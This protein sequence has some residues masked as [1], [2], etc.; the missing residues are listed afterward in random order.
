MHFRRPLARELNGLAR[1]ATCPRRL[2]PQN[3]VMPKRAGEKPR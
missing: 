3:K 2:G 1:D